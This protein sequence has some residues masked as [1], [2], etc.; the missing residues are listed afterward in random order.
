MQ[1]TIR[2]G[3]PATEACDAL[4]V[5]VAADKT[6]S[7]PAAAVDAAAG[8]ALSAVVAR[9]DFDGKAKSTR[10]VHVGA[11]LKAQRVLLV[12]TGSGCDD[13]AENGRLTG[14]AAIQGLSGITIRS[15]LVVLPDQTDPRFVQGLTEGLALASYRFDR[16]RQPDE[17]ETVV[18][19]VTL[20]AGTEGTLAPCRWRST[21]R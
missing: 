11:G 16:Y 4:V 5:P 18:E 10:L 13:P 6:L 3:D 19:A 14:G 9:G 2:S 1:L 7:G 20:L 15:A 12:G 17:D 21:A 8:G